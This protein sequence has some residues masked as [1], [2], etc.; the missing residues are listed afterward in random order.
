MLR[1]VLYVLYRLMR[2][3]EKLYEYM[4]INIIFITDMSVQKSEDLLSVVISAELSPPNSQELFINQDQQV[5][6]L[7]IF[8]YS[9]F[10]YHN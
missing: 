8:M 9:I 5:C 3:F 4:Y 7:L 6:L 1:V 2:F 10:I